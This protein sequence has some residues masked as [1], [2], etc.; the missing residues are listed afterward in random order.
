MCA[1]LV[2]GGAG[3]S[4][5]DNGAHVKSGAMGR[6]LQQMKGLLR[7]PRGRCFIQQV[8]AAFSVGSPISGA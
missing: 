5:L 7:D 6:F 8:F 4:G 3:R 2:A 1:E